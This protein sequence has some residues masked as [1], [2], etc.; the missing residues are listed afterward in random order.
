MP[1]AYANTYTY[2]NSRL[3]SDGYSYIYSNAYRDSHS[4]GNIHAYTY[5]D[6]H[7]Y[8]YAYTDSDS[9][10][11]TDVRTAAFGNGQLVAGRRQCQRH[12]GRQQW[13]AARRSDL[14]AG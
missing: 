11:Y 13:H 2:A 5:G 8:V 9:Y 14:R 4:D 12:P 1:I 3:H 7:G 6:S 10:S